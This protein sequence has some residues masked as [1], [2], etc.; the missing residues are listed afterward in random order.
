MDDSKNLITSELLTVQGST[1]TNRLQLIVAERNVTLTNRVDRS[2]ARADKAVYQADKDVVTLTGSPQLRNEDGNLTGDIIVLD[3][4]H[5]T[6][7]SRG[8]VKTEM[9]MSGNQA[10]LPGAKAPADPTAAPRAPE[11]LTITAELM[12]AN[13]TNKTAVFTEKVLVDSSRMG[14]ES[15][16]L[17]IISAPGGT[18]GG[19]E[20]I[21]ADSGRVIVVSKSD[22]KRFTGTNAT[23]VAATDTV[24]LSG[25]PTYEQLG[26]KMISTFKTPVIWHRR[27]NTLTFKKPDIKVTNPSEFNKK[28]TNS[29]PK[30]K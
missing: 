12:Q 16:R 13:L 26:S 29:A 28:T 11:L 17:I 8:K 4:A 21:I 30:T 7:E 3:R 5:S 22:G 10:L 2:Q 15:G 23:Y 24:E 14:L 27:N 25:E 9:Q 19:L 6:M 20:R 18:N 1:T